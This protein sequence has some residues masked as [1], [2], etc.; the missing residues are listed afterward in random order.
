MDTGSSHTFI[1]R[2]IY[3]DGN[4]Q[5]YS[6]NSDKYNTTCTQTWILPRAKFCTKSS[7]L[8]QLETFQIITASTLKFSESSSSR[9]GGKLRPPRSDP[10]WSRAACTMKAWAA[11][12]RHYSRS[13][14]DSTITKQITPRLSARVPRHHPPRPPGIRNKHNP[15]NY[16]KLHH[17][18]HN[19]SRCFLTL[20]I[21]T[22]KVV[23]L[24]TSQK[25]DYFRFLDKILHKSHTRH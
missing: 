5:V 14:R 24:M 3:G 16:L 4:S 20:Q 10:N 2:T 25:A 19:T 7:K 17:L 22:L 15:P 6:I 23:G 11:S 1:T 9:K 8:Y 21:R 12:V 13:T 18:P